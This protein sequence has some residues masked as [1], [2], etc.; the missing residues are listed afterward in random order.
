MEHRKKHKFLTE[1]DRFVMEKLLNCGMS[2]T[3]VA[4]ELGVSVSTI[5]REY[6]RGV[7]KTATGFK[8]K[9]AEGQNNSSVALSKRG[10][11]AKFF[12]L[13]KKMLS[14]LEKLIAWKK[15]SP[16]A[17]IAK[18]R[19]D[20]YLVPICTR[21][22]Y[23][24]INEHRFSF[25]TNRHLPVKPYKTRTYKKIRA[26]RPPSGESIEDRDP[27]VNTREEFGH[28]EMDL[29]I[30]SR[31]GED[32][33][34]SLTERK[35]RFQLLRLIRR[36][37]EDVDGILD[38]FEFGLKSNFSTIFKTIT[39]D[40]G[41]EFRDYYSLRKSVFSTDSRLRIFYCHPYSSYER[42]SNEVQH[43][44]LRRFSPK[45]QKISL[46]GKELVSIQRWMNNYPRK[47]FGWENSHRRFLYEINHLGIKLSH[48]IKQIFAVD[49]S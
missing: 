12:D 32:V 16:A 48:T 27:A 45:H 17:A 30:G 25:L 3:V 49:D 7:V 14:R 2:F 11:K 13:D 29:V 24:Y 22:L 5:S 36:K 33:I 1:R 10:K 39:V 37:G 19:L 34:L 20:G 42:G 46:S 31:R 8:Y 47:M 18:L 9:G 43:R 23:S 21:T 26:K 6:A 41:A 40:N 44:L 28:W 35:T 15:Y 4:R 38:S